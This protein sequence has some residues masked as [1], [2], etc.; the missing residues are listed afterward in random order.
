MVGGGGLEVCSSPVC[1]RFGI[2]FLENP[3]IHVTIVLVSN[4]HSISV[5]IYTLRIRSIFSRASYI[6]V[7]CDTIRV[8][9]L[10][11]DIV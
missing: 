10:C 2:F 11:V 8:Y 4:R 7:E 3:F 9:S 6:I 5:L 1:A